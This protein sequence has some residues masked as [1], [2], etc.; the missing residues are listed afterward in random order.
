MVQASLPRRRTWTS[1][2]WLIASTAA[3]LIAL[4]LGYT[5]M[6]WAIVVIAA[7]SGVLLLGGGASARAAGQPAP[8][9]A[10]Q[11]PQAQREVWKTDG[12]IQQAL[13]VP[14]QATEG[15]QT[16]LTID[17]YVLVNAEGQV[18]YALNREARAAA[19][20]PVVVTV[21]GEE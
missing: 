17:G 19:S 11:A 21:L 14:A 10:G 15:Y 6:L 20:D 18:V 1:T 12:T 3:M 2:T 9:G 8:A 5:L 4:A 13:I 7:L 16:V